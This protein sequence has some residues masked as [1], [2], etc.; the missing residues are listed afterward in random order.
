MNIE[1]LLKLQIE[2]STKF[3]LGYENNLILNCCNQ[4]WLLL[5]S[6]L[7]IYS[8]LISA[9]PIRPGQHQSVSPAQAAAIRGGGG[10]LS[11]NGPMITSTPIRMAPESKA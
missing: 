7:F 4:L 6:N 5:C 1:I 2:Y 8:Y 9:K 11:Q 10:G 3:K